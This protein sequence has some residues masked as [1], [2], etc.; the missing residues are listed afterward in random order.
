MSYST[1]SEDQIESQH[2]ALF[3]FLRYELFTASNPL[4]KS[5]GLYLNT[6]NYPKMETFSDRFR[7]TWKKAQ[8]V[9]GLCE[10][11]VKTSIAITELKRTLIDTWHGS[12]V[13]VILNTQTMSSHKYF[14]RLWKTSTRVIF[15]REKNVCDYKMD[16]ADHKHWKWN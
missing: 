2:L 12:K 14:V 16:V 1:N 5:I 10:L 8:S 4:K 7:L 3:R 15:W 6:L 13:R 9:H 11:T